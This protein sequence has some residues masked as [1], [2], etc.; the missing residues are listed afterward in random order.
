[1]LRW[2]IPTVVAVVVGL[3]TLLGFLLPVSAFESIRIILVRAA[4][5]LAA[6]AFILGYGNLLRVHAARILKRQAK[7]LIPSLIVVIS[8]VASLVLVLVQGQ[9]GP[10]V[11]FLVRAVLVPGESA[12]LALTAVTLLLAGMRLYRSR[13]HINSVLFIVVALLTL[14]SAA[15]LIYPP[16]FKTVM[17]FVNAVAT[18]G[19][20]GLLLG[21]ALGTIITGLRVILG[22]DRPHSGG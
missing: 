5:V 11:S 10:T 17:D 14:L 18:G 21:V 4:T 7:Y 1:M 9:S 2:F 16:L 3:V 13:R 19:L 15:P 12:L 20:R 22:I 8:A 6:F